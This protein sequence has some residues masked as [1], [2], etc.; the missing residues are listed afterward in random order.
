MSMPI[1]VM[2]WPAAFGSPALRNF[3]MEEVK[4]SC[5]TI[6]LLTVMHQMEDKGLHA[7][8]KAE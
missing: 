3:T 6:L 1:T 8:H 7:D 4:V 5:M 2:V